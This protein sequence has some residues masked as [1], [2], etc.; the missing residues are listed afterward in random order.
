[1]DRDRW[2]TINRIFH[3]ALE[4]DPGQRHALVA[5]ESGGD[6]E[7][8]TEVELLLLADADAG[9]YL[10]SPL[11]PSECL[12][13]MASPLTVGDVLCDRF[14]II[15]EIAEGGMGHVF[16]AFDTELAVHVA[17]KV[18]RPEIA[19][20]PG[21]ITRFRQEVRLARTITHPNICRTFDLE[22]ETR[23]PDPNNTGLLFLTM[24]L[25]PGETLASRIRRSGAIPLHDAF[26]VAGQI[27]DALCAAHALGIVHRDIKP[28]NVM[29]VPPDKE[30]SMTEVRAV[31]TDFG[32]ARL[33]PV[34]VVGD[35]SSLSHTPRAIGTFAYMAPEQLE[36]KPV[37]PATD[38]YSFGLILFEMATGTKAFPAESLL[39][40]LSH[41][42][43]GPPPSPKSLVNRLPTNWCRAIESCLQIVPSA[44]PRNARDVIAILAGEGKVSSWI[45]WKALRILSSTIRN[46]RI[47][48]FVCIFFLAA[49]MAL[50]VDVFRIHELKA[51]SKVG[52]GALLY[53]PP[54]N[55]QTDE[56]N[57]NNLT[58]LL[59]GDLTQ[60][61]QIN[62]LDQGR[63]G[64]ILQQMTKPPETVIDPLI[65]R[66]IAM[67][68]GAPRVAFATV[69]GSNGNYKLNIDIQQPDATSPARYRD[70]WSQNFVWRS[71]DQS[72][73]KTAISPEL[74]TAIRSA[75]D[76]VRRRAG[77]SAND[78]ASL[79]APPE[80][81][82]TGNWEALGEFVIAEKLQSRQATS[83]AIIAL[84]NAIRI[85]PRFSLAW[86]R[87]GD[88]LVSVGRYKEGYTA[89]TQAL[90]LSQ[91]RRLTRREQDRI[92]GIYALDSGDFSSSEQ[93]F[94][95]YAVYYESD[96]RGWFYRGYPLLMLGRTEE[97]IN[98]LKRAF[99]IDPT[100]GNAPWELAR[101]HIVEG[102]YQE[103]SHWASIL[104]QQG[105]LGTSSYFDGVIAFI[106]Q[107]YDDASKSFGTV[108][109]SSRVEDHSWGYWLEARL[110]AERGNLQEALETLDQG[111]R[112]DKMQGYT[113]KEA[114]K[115]LSKAYIENKLGLYDQ[116]QKDINQGLSLDASPQRL[117][118]ASSIL[119][120]VFA[121][122]QGVPSSDVRRALYNLERRLPDPINSVI[123]QIAR[124]RVRGEILF[125]ENKIKP[126]VAE[127]EAA[128]DLDSPITSREYLARA[129]QKAAENESSPDDAARLRKRS[130]EAYAVIALRPGLAWLQTTEAVPGFYGDQLEAYLHL[131]ILDH[132]M[133]DSNYGYLVRLMKLREPSSAFASEFQ[134]ALVRTDQGHHQVPKETQ[135]AGN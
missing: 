8:Q 13:P 126:A 36:G 85:D 93:A 46:P 79:D 2:T 37:S 123:T 101:A 133:D 40:G 77:E 134:H 114:D 102:N 62:L 120:A 89:Y 73:S 54:V 41:R 97:A 4:V 75:S 65:A 9:S 3:A 105:D 67:R 131:A 25:L 116:S 119:G 98:S 129:L 17:L 95:D 57:F 103:A 32:L 58:Q 63:V 71:S 132:R 64:D 106:A 99:A 112:E 107:R 24:E 22:R 27:A 88:L 108:R 104:R 59:Q 28:S 69:T 26:R 18:V 121:R 113:A 38:I 49:A 19:S 127:F 118:T 87:L 55:N 124:H 48:L 60:S 47:A 21:G 90:A 56:Q 7:L 111:I 135:H 14:R 11:I 109:L 44:R 78:I 72:A 130:M 96:Y 34:R 94:R 110:D 5:S 92:K 35:L 100:R 10:E 43:T 66:E 82:T 125:A 15:R 50:L 20:D 16:E 68:A 81:V 30:A 6:H 70:H 12:V 84:Q 31:I 39:T 117:M 45:H 29:L 83:N 42:L 23:L 76:W 74:L 128:S 115:F 80:D 51:D 86:A 1:M 122:R 52:R 91:D 61:A 33:D 53:L